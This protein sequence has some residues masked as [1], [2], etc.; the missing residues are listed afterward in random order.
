MD[1]DTQQG[2]YLDRDDLLVV[3]LGNCVLCLEWLEVLLSSLIC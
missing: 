2:Y 3:E 1:V